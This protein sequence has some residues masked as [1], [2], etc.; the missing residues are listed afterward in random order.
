MGRIATS[1]GRSTSLSE[2]TQQEQNDQENGERHSD[3][4]ADALVQGVDEPGGLSPRA[5][6]AQGIGLVARSG[7][8]PPARRLGCTAIRARELIG[9]SDFL[10]FPLR[11]HEPIYIQRPFQQPRR[12]G[13]MR[14]LLSR[15]T[16][17]SRIGNFPI[18]SFAL[19]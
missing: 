18:T 7:W 15:G 8:R 5:C 13:S 6:G 10:G 3:F 1:I 16:V 14:N 19:R 2:E 12:Q 4:P 11:S 17:V 9:L